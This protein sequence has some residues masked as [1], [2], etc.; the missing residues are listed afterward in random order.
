MMTD[1]APESGKQWAEVIAMLQSL[2]ADQQVLA[3]M[4]EELER[5]V[6]QFKADINNLK[7]EESANDPTS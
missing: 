1:N 3:R 5:L 4:G 6:E 2:R 7:S